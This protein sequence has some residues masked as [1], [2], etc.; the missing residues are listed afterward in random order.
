M[1]LDDIWQKYSKGSRVGCR[2]TVCMF[3]FSCRFAF[4]QLFVLHPCE[5]G[6]AP[7]YLFDADCRAHRRECQRLERRYRRKYRLDDRRRSVEA[8][9]RRFS[10]YRNKRDEYWSNRL[11]QSGRSSAA[12]WRSMSS[13]LRRNSDVTASTSHSAQGFADFFQQEDRRHPVSDFRSSVATGHQSSVVVTV[14]VPAVH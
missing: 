6:L 2:P 14:V 9:R 1:D 7:R 3:Q 11:L 13:V 12:L 10:V 8:T 4:Y 5:H